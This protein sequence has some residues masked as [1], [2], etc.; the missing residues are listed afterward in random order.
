MDVFL[1]FK[2]FDTEFT[3]KSEPISDDGTLFEL[4]P[5]GPSYG[6]IY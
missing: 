3:E 5:S 4:K 2:Y 6:K 1:K